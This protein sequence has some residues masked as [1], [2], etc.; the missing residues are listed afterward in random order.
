MRVIKF[1]INVIMSF[2]LM[3][4]IAI[5]IA[6][7]FIN[8]KLLNKDYFK[9]KIDDTGFYSQLSKEINDG[10]ENYVYQ[11]GLPED[12]V[13]DIFND[14]VLRNDINSI[15][16]YV[17]DNGELNTSEAL[18]KQNLDN[19]ITAY[20]N[21]NNIKLNE[22]GKSNIEGYEVLISNEYRKKVVVSESLYSTAK[23]TVTLARKIMRRVR[24]MPITVCIIIII[25]LLIIN[26][27][28]PLDAIYF[29][30]IS[31]LSCGGLL[32]VMDYFV[33]KNIKFDGLLIYSKSVTNLF[34]NVCNEILN[35]IEDY[36]TFLMVCGGVSILVTAILNS[37][38][39]KTDENDE[40][41][42]FKPKRRKKYYSQNV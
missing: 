16:A 25:L 15:I 39:K 8:N 12:I 37:F 23:D 3:V 20:L 5:C 30:G 6:Q 17:F 18:V 13:Q 32:K 38:V 2:L 42:R 21:A 29:G 24:S 40:T 36:S 11:S 33:N 7:N 1:F 26:R 35:M 9:A 34:V 41:P 19:K 10:F 31:M 22:Q 27:K 14:E 4:F 28:N